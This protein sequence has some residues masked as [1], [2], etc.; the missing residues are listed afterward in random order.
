MP[1]THIILNY[2]WGRQESTPSFFFIF[3][4][5][6][7]MSINAAKLELI[8][9]GQYKVWDDNIALLIGN[10]SKIEQDYNMLMRQEYLKEMGIEDKEIKGKK[11]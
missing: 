1:N 7:E 10:L 6:Q 3:L 4:R 5:Y 11:K 9:K 8:L 2:G